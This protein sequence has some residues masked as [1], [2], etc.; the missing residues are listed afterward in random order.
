MSTG[1]A[2]RLAEFDTGTLCESGATAL[3]PGLRPV[4]PSGRLLGRA[5]TASCPAGQN[6]MLHRAVARAEP[7]DVIVARCGGRDHG[8]WG[9]VLAAASL[10]R[11]IRGLVIEGS[12]RDVEAMRDLGFPVFAAGVALPGT[13]KAVDGS[14]GEP[15]EVRGAIVRTGDTVVA[16]ESG[17]VVIAPPS[18]ADVHGRARARSDGERVM[19]EA[20]R[21]GRTTLELL[22]LPPS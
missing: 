13:G 6:L 10:A 15:V 22:G 8:Y 17:I 12:V 20:L 16:D 2:D 18:L 9:E 14:V 7:G 11:G 4:W 3:G 5:L 21:A 1:P 19:I